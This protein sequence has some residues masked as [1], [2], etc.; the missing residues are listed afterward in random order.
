MSITLEDV[1]TAIKVLQAFLR[2]QREAELILRKFQAYER[3][4]GAR[5]FT[6]DDFVSMAFEQAKA[7]REALSQP[8]V[9]ITEELSEEDLK[10]IKEIKEKLE[11]QKK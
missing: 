9:E 5:G 2:K 4:I 6:L 7:R 8:E 3:R 1:E 10:R 11:Q